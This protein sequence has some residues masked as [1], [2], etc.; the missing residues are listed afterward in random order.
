MENIEEVKAQVKTLYETLF[1]A[2]YRPNAVQPEIFEKPENPY[3]GF[4]KKTIDFLEDLRKNF[5]TRTIKRDDELLK[6][7]I[8]KHRMGDLGV[9]LRLP[10][11][12]K[13]VSVITKGEGKSKRIEHF[14]F[15][16]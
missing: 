4:K 3:K 14:Y 10:E 1:G 7:L 12:R 5:G 9:A 15:L 13:I 11:D 8:W 6:D 2:P 16:Y